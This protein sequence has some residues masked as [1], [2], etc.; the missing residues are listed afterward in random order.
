VVRTVLDGVEAGALEVVVDEWRAG[1]KSSLSRDP[2]EFYGDAARP[3][4]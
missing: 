1:V 3:T 4:A 2:G